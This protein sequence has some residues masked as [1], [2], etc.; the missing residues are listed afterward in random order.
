[1]MTIA[2]N[3]KVLVAD[4]EAHA[5]MVVFVIAANLATVFAGTAFSPHTGAWLPQKLYA[6]EMILGKIIRL[7]DKDDSPMNKG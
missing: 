5:V 2:P 6:Y 4:P 1:M 7:P 3:D